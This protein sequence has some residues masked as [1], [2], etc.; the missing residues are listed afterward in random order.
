MFQPGYRPAYAGRGRDE[1][2]KREKFHTTSIFCRTT[3]ADVG[4][5]AYSKQQTKKNQH[6]SVFY[7]FR[8]RDERPFCS[9][10]C[11]GN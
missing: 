9:T 5:L 1:G 6:W 3:R 4:D 10:R 11:V 7:F 8:K 2:E